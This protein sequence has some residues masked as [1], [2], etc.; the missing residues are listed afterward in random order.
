MQR[1]F[2][3][4]VPHLFLVA[5]IVLQAV[6]LPGPGRALPAASAAPVTSAAAAAVPAST[7]TFDSPLPPPA[8]PADDAALA[9]RIRATPSWVE[10][11]GVVTFTVSA[12]AQVGA[13]VTGLVV[14]DVL[15]DGFV[16]VPGS[17]AGLAYDPST[18]GLT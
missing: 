7:S 1:R 6:L 15:P 17:A 4:M 2:P 8:E 12:G 5:V 10:P 13:R 18:N 14:Q 16:Y 9:L 11:G 3:S